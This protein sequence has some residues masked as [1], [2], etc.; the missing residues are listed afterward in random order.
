[1]A[2][3]ENSTGIKK[4]KRKNP[5]FS[6][7]KFIFGLIVVLLLIAAG[8]LAFSALDR[9]SSLASIP[10]NYSAYVHTDSA[11]A[12]LNPLLDLHATEVLLSSG[13]F[14]KYRKMFMTLRS[15]PLRSNPLFKFLLSRPV[16]FASYGEVQNA[17]FVAAVNLGPFSFASRLADS[18]WKYLIKYKSGFSVPGLEYVEDESL[19]HFCYTAGESVF[20]VKALKNLVIISDSEELFMTSCF[21]N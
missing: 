15:S 1:M 19:P 10:R 11:F 17:N 2:D 5:F 20:Y 13:Q 14:V 7:V 6:F 8:I 4:S 21:V 3:S 9:R 12:A 18:C 16:D